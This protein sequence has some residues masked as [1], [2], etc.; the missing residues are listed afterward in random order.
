MEKESKSVLVTGA[1]GF[2][3]KHLIEKLLE[4]EF[5]VKAVVRN[6]DQISKEFGKKSAITFYKGDMRNVN[7]WDNKCFEDTTF[8]H[9]FSDPY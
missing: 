9:V 4:R 2:I 8:V 1:S 5:N 3:G 7:S 6:P